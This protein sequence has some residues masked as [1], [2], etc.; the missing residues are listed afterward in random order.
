M[1]LVKVSNTQ[2]ENNVVND[3]AKGATV[4]NDVGKVV[5]QE[6]AR[7]KKA[8][9][10]DCG[11]QNLKSNINISKKATKDSNT[12]ATKNAKSAAGKYS[13]SASVKD[14]KSTIAEQF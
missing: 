7:V 3:G 9:G 4:E 8:N 13:K 6:K 5:I 10:K 12:T 1:S 14:S 11:S 2:K